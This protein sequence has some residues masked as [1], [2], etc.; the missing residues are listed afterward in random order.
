M[1]T[2]IMAGFLLFLM[3]PYKC[4]EENEDTTEI[5]ADGG[6]YDAKDTEARAAIADWE[7]FLLESEAVVD[8]ACIKIAQATDKMESSPSKH[9]GK[10]RSAIIKADDRM[11]KLS[12]M[13]LYARKIKTENYK[14]SDAA[15]QDIDRFKQ[16]F[17]SKQGELENALRELEA[18]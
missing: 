11:E 13:L 9:K 8:N 18:K 16:D 14:L 15:L 2:F 6:S 17:K 7:K 5:E 4:A 10:F 12:D 1:K 3:S